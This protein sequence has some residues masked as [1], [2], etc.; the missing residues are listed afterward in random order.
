[1]STENT[2]LGTSKADND[3]ADILL[4]ISRI[5]SNVYECKVAPRGYRYADYTQAWLDR[6]GCSPESADE[7]KTAQ[8]TIAVQKMLVGQFGTDRLRAEAPVAENMELRFVDRETRSNTSFDKSRVQCFDLL[9]VR[10]GVAFEF[11]LSDAFA[12]FFKDVLKAILDSRVHKLYLCMR[13][14]RYKGD[15]K[16]G[17]IKVSESPMVNQYITLARLYK[18]EIVLFDLCPEC[19]TCEAVLP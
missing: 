19:N 1:M 9:D 2:P 7:R 16:S 11:S 18:L 3:V 15:K 17:F 10:H 14:H 8:T 13:N 6:I 4:E 12:E 5:F